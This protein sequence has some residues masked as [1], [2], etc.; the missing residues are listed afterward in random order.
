MWLD[1][2]AGQALGNFPA[3][4]PGPGAVRGKPVLLTK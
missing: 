2:S 1:S 3:T 4:A